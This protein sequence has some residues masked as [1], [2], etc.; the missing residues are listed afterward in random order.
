[1][2]FI[3]LSDPHA[4]MIKPVGR[5]D[6]IHATLM[7]K[8]GYVLGYAKRK[9]WPIFISGDL[10]DRPQE[11]KVMMLVMRMI[12]KSR[13]DVYV[14]YGQHDMYARVSRKSITSI[15]ILIKSGIITLLRSVPITVDGVKVYGSSWGEG[16]PIP[17]GKH[18][19]KN[20]LVAH[21][22]SY[23]SKLYPGQHGMDV[24]S[25]AN[26]YPNNLYDLIHI[27]DIHRRFIYEGKNIVV[28][29]GPLLRLEATRYNIKKHKPSFAVYDHEKNKVKFIEVPHEDGRI[30]LD[31]THRREIT[32]RNKYLEKFA[33]SLK[34]ID[35]KL[36]QGDV[37][38]DVDRY[39][40]ENDIEDDVIEALNEIMEEADGS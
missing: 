2:N 24:E 40:E 35:F 1:M 12:K 29:T 28:N 34:K 31:A 26:K 19:G 8:F 39:I 4:T 38:K 22:P 20:M 15:N 33:S 30:V 37:K 32:R 18:E 11:W 25:F 6:D 17:R 5:R 13:V 10:F 23:Q 16:I 27:G 36:Y 3:L 14:V 7:L 9:G 21:K